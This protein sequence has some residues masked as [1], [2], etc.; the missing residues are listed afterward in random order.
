MTRPRDRPNNR[1]VAIPH[2]AW[3]SPIVA[4]DLVG[5]AARVSFPVFHGDALWWSELRPADGGR[6]VVVRSVAGEPAED[7][8]PPPWHARTRVHEYGG[9]CWTPA[10]LPDGTLSLV[11]AHD[12]DQRLWRRDLTAPDGSA[13]DRDPIPLTPVP[14]EPGADRFAEPQLHPDGREVW[15]IRERH[16][17]GRVARHLVAVAVDGSLAVR[18][19]WGGSDFLAGARL[20]PDGRRLAF[21]TWDHPSMPWDGTTCRVARVSA[22]GDLGEPVPVLGGPQESVL[23]PEWADATT[24]YA[25]SDRSGWWNLYRVPLPRAGGAA[26]EPEPLCPMTEE[27]AEPLWQLGQTTYA[28][29]D[30]GALAVLHGTATRRLDVLDPVRGRLRSVDLPYG[31]YAPMLAGRGSEVAAIAGS[32]TQAWTLVRINTGSGRVTSVR[33]ASDGDVDAAYLPPAR[34]TVVS[35]LGGREVHVVVYPPTHPTAVG[36][37]GESPPYIV[38]VHG[39]PTSQVLPVLDLAK[40]YLTSRGLG[41]V[42]VNYGG[43]SGFGRAYRERLRG[44][45]GVVDVEDCV[46]AV[47]ALV[48]RG[49]ADGARL[50]IRGGSAGGWTVL[51]S[52]TRTDVFAAGTSYFGVA[53]LLSFAADTHDFESRYLDGLV[54]RLPEDRAVLIDRAPLTHVDRLACPVLLL[55]GAEDKV[56]PPAQAECFRDALVRK[57]IAHAYRLFPGEQHGFRRAETI[58]A[59]AEAELSFYG[60][61]LGFDPPGVPR[62]ELTGG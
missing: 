53:E 52:L 30:S 10:D 13:L 29:L 45:W 34:A 2:G 3:P 23:Q 55:Q 22:T 56:V 12:D 51:A 42:D 59:A 27:F 16:H 15:C 40:A 18:E 25:V 37:D 61:V 28:R 41:V 19:L 17:D 58:I 24:L 5:Q 38:F 44:G 47:R 4:R 1:R 26:L 54:G 48:D 6:T 7:V 57:G 35:G 11:F 20:S 8:L 46:S 9:A 39:G 33:R 50:A 49:E 43:S 62:L 36:P 60:Q 14:A 21:I 31:A 32:P